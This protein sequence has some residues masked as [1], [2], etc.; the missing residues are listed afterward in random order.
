MKILILSLVLPAIVHGQ[1]FSITSSKI[2][3]GGGASSGGSFSLAGTIGQHDTGT[4]SGGN[5]T[6]DGGF[7]SAA[8][9]V[10]LPG[11][12][13]LTIRSAGNNFILSWPA[14]SGAFRLETSLNLGGANSWGPVSVS[15]ATNNG[16]VSVT[17]PAT[18]GNSFFR[19]KNP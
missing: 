17:I 7:W 14:T 15:P 9:A 6:L 10:A 18:P 1:S 3:G 2:A 16:L 19:L 8:I 12:P 13:L 5:Y 11:S 4:M